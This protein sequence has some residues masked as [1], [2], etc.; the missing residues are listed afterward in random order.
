MKGSIRRV[1]KAEKDQEKK[2]SVEKLLAFCRKGRAEKEA[3]IQA[4]KQLLKNEFPNDCRYN[5]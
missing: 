3:K 2:E 4:A 1:S 5:K